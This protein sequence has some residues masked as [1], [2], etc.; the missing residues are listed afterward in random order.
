MHKWKLSRTTAGAVFGGVFGGELVQNV[1]DARRKIA[2]WQSE[3]NEQRPHSSM[4]YPTP[5]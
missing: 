2:A 3:Y 1:F 5:N 4:G